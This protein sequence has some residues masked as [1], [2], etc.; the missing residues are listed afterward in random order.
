METQKIYLSSDEESEELTYTKSDDSIDNTEYSS[1]MKPKPLIGSNITRI[2]QHAGIDLVVDYWSKVTP[3]LTDHTLFV[4][5]VH[6]DI[7]QFLAPLVMSGLITLTRNIKAIPNETAYPCTIFAKSDKEEDELLKLSHFDE[8]TL[9][10]PE[11]IINAECKSKIVYL[12]DIIHEWIFGRVCLYILYDLLFRVPNNIVYIYGNHDLN[13]LA[14]Y[15]LYRRML[16]NMGAIM[17][18]TYDTMAKEMNMYKSLHFYNFNI[19][20]NGND[21]GLG[22]LFMYAYLAH[23]FEP[24]Y[25]IFISKRG[26]LCKYL[27]IDNVPFIVSHCVWDMKWLPAFVDSK[28][29]GFNN[30][31]QYIHYS[32]YSR[33]RE[34]KTKDE[35][36]E[37]LL[38]LHNTCKSKT[39]PSPV[40]VDVS[41]IANTHYKGYE[42]RELANAMNDIIDGSQYFAL[43]NNIMLRN[44]S[45]YNLFVNQITGHT[46]G[47][48]WRDI[49]VN[50]G[51][52]TYYNERLTKLTPEQINKRY[53]FYWDFNASAGYVKDE[54]SRP[55]FVYVGNEHVNDNKYGAEDISDE[56]V[57]NEGVFDITNL[58]AF[59]YI[60]SNDKDSVIVCSK[61]SKHTGSIR[62]IVMDSTSSGEE[63]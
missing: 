43:T 59:N 23:L 2:T 26:C 51:E 17:Q 44:R 53:L 33:V 18:T 13:V 32:V 19:E 60:L 63:N 5:D 12:G 11:Y 58:P 49:G 52:S 3:T 41:K 36:K 38:Y 61:K 25:D 7:N 27:T 31:L 16:I 55:D 14:I 48:T 30:N 28:A 21:N 10:I 62:K 24:L 4:G 39:G 40:S 1:K 42:Y 22:K 56:N 15:P 29:S 20:Y 6:A 34:E 46:P 9:Y 8:L 35:S 47:G 50:V 37:L 54:F 57:L 45:T